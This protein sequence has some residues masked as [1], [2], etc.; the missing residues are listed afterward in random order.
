MTA[1]T[2]RLEFRTAVSKLILIAPRG[3]FLQEGGDE[4]SE[5]L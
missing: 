1:A 4:L 2:V 5:S 3:D